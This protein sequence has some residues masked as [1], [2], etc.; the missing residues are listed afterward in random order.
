MSNELLTKEE[1]SNWLTKQRLIYNQPNEKVDRDF[2]WFIVSKMVEL[3]GCICI[4]QVSVDENQ[5]AHW[6]HSDACGLPT[7]PA[8]GG[9][10]EQD[11]KRSRLATVLAETVFNNLVTAISGIV[12]SDRDRS[13]SRDD[14]ARVI[15]E[16]LMGIRMEYA[17]D[18]LSRCPIVSCHSKPCAFCL[19]AAMREFILI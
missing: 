10:T 19:A 3:R 9:P 18:K 2:H 12:Q 6:I 14:I 17:G 11:L 15:D 1:L 7:S 4:P 13:L 5:Q 8:D 16:R